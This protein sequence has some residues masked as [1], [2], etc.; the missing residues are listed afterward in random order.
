MTR[1]L[2]PDK[3]TPL[4]PKTEITIA[5]E[6]IAYHRGLKVWQLLENMLKETAS[7]EEIRSSLKE[8]KIHVTELQN[9]NKA[10]ELDS[11]AK[12]NANKL[13]KIDKTLQKY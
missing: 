5:L 9:N 4:W 10:I 3:Y 1:V 11:A 13:A 12:K 7:K 6:A 2:N 8:Y